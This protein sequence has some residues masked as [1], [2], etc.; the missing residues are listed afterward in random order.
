[1]RLRLA[2]IVLASI[3]VLAG[4]G[5]SSGGVTAASDPAKLTGDDKL[6]YDDFMAGFDDEV[7]ITR[8]AASCTTL[9]VMAKLGTKRM[10]ELK[11]AKTSLA[12]GRAFAESLDECSALK[13]MMVLAISQAGTV[14]PEQAACLTEEIDPAVLRTMLAGTMAGDAGAMRSAEATAALAA[15]AKVCQGASGATGTK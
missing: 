6:A 12:D 3:V 5:G 1:M 4:C 11:S 9:R 10:L 8:E 15:A 2:S 7:P 13:P 14:T